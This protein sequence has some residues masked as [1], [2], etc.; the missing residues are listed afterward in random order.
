MTICTHSAA[1]MEDK[2]T[3]TITWYPT[4]SHYRNTEPTSPCHILIMPS[5]WLRSDEL[6]KWF[7]STSVRTRKVRISPSPKTGDGC[8]THS[9]PLVSNKQTILCSRL[10]RYVSIYNWAA[11]I[12]AAKAGEGSAKKAALR[13][14]LNPSSLASNNERDLLLL[15]IRHEWIAR[16]KLTIYIRRSLIRTALFPAHSVRLMRVSR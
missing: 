9:C 16:L 11:P 1:P 2:A 3:S 13:W 4:R 12:R 10:Q 15:R 6:K 7:D 5:A 8:S 14:I